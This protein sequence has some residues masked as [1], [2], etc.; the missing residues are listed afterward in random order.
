V[1]SLYHLLKL[2]LSGTPDRAPPLFS[3]GMMAG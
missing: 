2:I 3:G 1:V